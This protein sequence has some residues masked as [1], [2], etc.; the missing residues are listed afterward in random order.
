[1][2]PSLGLWKVSCFLTYEVKKIIS[3]MLV[4]TLSLILSGCI[5]GDDTS[6]SSLSA[7]LS[8]VDDSATCIRQRQDTLK[9]LT[10]DPQRAWIQQKPDA[11]AYAS[12]VRLFAFKTKKKE[13]TCPELVAARTEAEA[14]PSTLRSSTHG[15]SI[16]QVSR[17]LLLASEIGRE[18]NKEYAARC[19]KT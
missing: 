17:G 3:I 5:A 4:A 2:D 14:A 12:G 15:L 10:S 13:L 9:Y 18:L 16:A 11:L 19:K 7:G 1:M 6:M 8:C